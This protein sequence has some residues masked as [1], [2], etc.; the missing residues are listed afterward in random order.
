MGFRSGGDDQRVNQLV[1]EFAEATEFL[2]FGNRNL[3]GLPII[4]DAIKKGRDETYEDINGAKTGT[5]GELNNGGSGVGVPCFTS[6]IDSSLDG[7]EAMG[8]RN[9]VIQLS[10]ALG[11]AI[12]ADAMR[13]GEDIQWRG[14]SLEPLAV[15][16]PSQHGDLTTTMTMNFG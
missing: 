2:L 14:F 8:V 10:H 3:S 1:H 9:F 11:H 7:A 5:H 15:G 13:G 6:L 12:R 4:P 16:A